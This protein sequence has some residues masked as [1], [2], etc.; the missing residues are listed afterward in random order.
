V[1]N[2]NDHTSRTVVAK[3][4]N[5]LPFPQRRY[6]VCIISSIPRTYNTQVPTKSKNVFNN[7]MSLSAP[8]CAELWDE[9]E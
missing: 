9:Y 6:V 7:L 1:T 8:T 3:M 5:L 2:L 4:R